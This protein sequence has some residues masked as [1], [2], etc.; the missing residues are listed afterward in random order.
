VRALAQ[1]HGDC[2]GEL[3]DAELDAIREDAWL[4]AS[5]I[6]PLSYSFFVQSSAFA[7]AERARDCLALVGLGRNEQSRTFLDLGGAGGG[8]VWAKAACDCNFRSDQTPISRPPTS[9][10]KRI[11]SRVC[12]VEPSLLLRTC[13]AS[14]M[15]DAS[16]VT[17]L[18]D[19]PEPNG[20]NGVFD[21]VHIE[22]LVVAGCDVF[23]VQLAQQLQQAKVSNL[24]AFA[25]S[26]IPIPVITRTPTM[27]LSLFSVVHWSRHSHLP[28]F[29]RNVNEGV[30]GQGVQ[31]T[32]SVCDF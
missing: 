3:E 19:V 5:K 20:E 12:V 16:H 25:I 27:F 21:A 15:P 1:A 17:F 7:A 29:S 23:N 6:L 24:V 31:L 22:T 8:C 9:S 30:W 26:H 11:C 10:N 13:S 18:A 28:A 32:R 2:S 14:A 4:T